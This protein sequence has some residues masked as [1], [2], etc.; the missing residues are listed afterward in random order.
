MTRCCVLG[1]QLIPEQKKFCYIFLWNHTGKLPDIWHKPSVWRTV[2]CNAVL[3]LRHVHFLFYATL[4]IVDIGKFAYKIISV[5]FFSGTT[6]AS[7][8]IFGTEHQYGKLYRVMQSWIC[9]MSTSCFTRL[10][11]FK[12]KEV[13]RRQVSSLED[14]QLSPFNINSPYQGRYVIYYNNRTHPPY[15]NGYS[16]KALLA[17]CEVEVNGK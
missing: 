5:T 11:I 2:S 14:L 17:L 6:E 16:A 13:G 8:L 12:R 4:N 9:G 15:P 10:W 3:N 7:I 1:T